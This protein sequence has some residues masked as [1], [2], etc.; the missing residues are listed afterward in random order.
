MHLRTEQS[1]ALRTS[2]IG[3]VNDEWYFMLWTTIPRFLFDIFTF[4]KYPS[5]QPW[6]KICKIYDKKARKWLL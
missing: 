1:H 6:V 5:S 4:F 3:Y 2:Y